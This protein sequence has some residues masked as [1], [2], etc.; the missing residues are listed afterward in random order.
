MRSLGRAIEYEADR[1]IALLEAGEPVV[2]QTRHWDEDAGR[3]QTLR[4]KE[5]AYDYRYFLE[6][7]LVP[8]VPDAEW[9]RAVA[10]TMAPMPA[11]RRSR[12]V[13]L[14]GGGNGATAAQVDQVATVVDLGLDP[15]VLAAAAAGVAPA[16]ALARTANEA[17]NDAESA[18]DLDPQS[19]VALL[20][21]EADGSLT[22]TQ[23]KAVLAEMLAHGEG[24][25]RPSPRPRGSRP[26]PRT[27]SWPPW[28][29]WWP[30]TPTSGPG[31]ATGT[32]GSGGRPSSARSWRPPGARPTARR[33]GPSW[34][35][36][37]TPEVLDADTG[38]GVDG[39]GPGGQVGPFRR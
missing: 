15:L 16:L 28:P 27:R 21:M 23:A 36:Y 1:Q 12:L 7:D 6:P 24:T 39:G 17:A 25:P 11:V 8:L 18:R 20:S 2:Q 38:T 31:T 29:T 5:D 4:T 14:L 19:Y 32:N 34:S 9:I 22:A 3:T 26:C 37:G 13:E 30:P 10:D 35:A 33:C